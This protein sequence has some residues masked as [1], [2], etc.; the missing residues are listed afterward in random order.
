VGTLYA[1]DKR[2]R[3]GTDRDKLAA[4]TMTDEVFP[5]HL[6]SSVDSVEWRIEAAATKLTLC[7]VYE[8]HG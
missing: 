8:Q 3:Q 4:L 5:V 2:D 6:P 7:E 1:T